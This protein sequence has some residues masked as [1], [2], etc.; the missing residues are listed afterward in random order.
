VSVHIVRDYL[1]R[2][3]LRPV[4]YTTGGYGLSMTPRC[5]GCALRAAFEAGIA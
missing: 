5:N 3:L 1:L 2:G 4:A